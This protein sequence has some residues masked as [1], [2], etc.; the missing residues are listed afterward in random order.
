MKSDAK[1]SVVEPVPDGPGSP[2]EYVSA[3][4]LK[5]FLECRLKFFIER[6]LGMK[7]PTTANLHVGRAVHAG[8]QE[9]HLAVWEGHD[10][11]VPKRT[12]GFR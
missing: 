11:D 1:M 6:V 9:Y 3:S 4:R 5:C 2:L 12:R 10:M 8:L 7:A